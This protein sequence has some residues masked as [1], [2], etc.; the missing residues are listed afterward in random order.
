MKQKPEYIIKWFTVGFIVFISIADFL[1]LLGN[2]PFLKDRVPALTLLAV[3]MII[4]YLGQERKTKL[5]VIENTLTVGFDKLL[6][7]HYEI[8][9]VTLKD[10]EELYNYAS[11]RMKDAKKT[12]DDLTWGPNLA[13]N[14]SN[15]QEA[16]N[17]YLETMKN[18]CMDTKKTIE[19]REVIAFPPK[20]NFERAEAMLKLRMFGYTLKYYLLPE[21]DLPPLISFMI[22]DS[23]EVIIAYYR[24]PYLKEN[25]RL[26]LRHPQIVEIFQ[27]YYNTVWHKAKILK[28]GEA[29]EKSAMEAIK[30]HLW[31][32]IPN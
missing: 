23:E 32:N 24:S 28:D 22:I 10:E 1:D 4:I 9:I 5:D 27:N 29:I 15:S 21:E 7:S 16:F 8:S 2:I 26:A 3:G 25:M 30:K 11:K 19:Y 14:S 13:D 18:I 6:Q 12:I 17:R 31:P 20:E